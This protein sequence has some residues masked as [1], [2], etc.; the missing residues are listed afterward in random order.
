MKL[1]YIT[2]KY[3]WP[4]NIIYAIDQ[5]IQIADVNIDA[6]TAV[7]D[8]LNPDY[9]KVMILR[10]KDKL[11]YKQIADIMG[12]TDSRIGQIIY[13]T[14]R[15]MRSPNVISKIVSYIPESVD[16]DADICELE[17]QT[18]ELHPLLRSGIRSIRDLCNLTE[19]DLLR[20]RNI[21]VGSVNNISQKLKQRGLSLKP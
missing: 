6:I 18:R 8:S 16:M 3:P 1:I 21:G 19:R 11:T 2:R 9:R 5:N 10:F 4:D 17:L 15:Y 14:C 20:I 12:V 7:L 13:A